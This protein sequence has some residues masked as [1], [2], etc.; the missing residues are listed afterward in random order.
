MSKSTKAQTSSVV[1]IISVLKSFMVP[2]ATREKEN[3]ILK[4]WS[5]NNLCCFIIEKIR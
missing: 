1:L 5:P 2:R 4:P 3:V